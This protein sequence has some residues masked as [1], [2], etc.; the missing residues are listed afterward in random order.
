MGRGR[1]KLVEV[2]AGART[3]VCMQLLLP[4][5]RQRLERLYEVVGPF[6]F[7][8]VLPAFEHG[9]Q[10][11]LWGT[12]SISREGTQRD[13]KERPLRTKMGGRRE[14]TNRWWLQWAC[15]PVA[16]ITRRETQLRHR[17]EATVTTRGV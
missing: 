11:L 6:L 4:R 9:G 1:G 12:V 15:M 16:D 13:Y 17:L 3:C 14:Q 7:F 5:E 2:G 10:R 8:F